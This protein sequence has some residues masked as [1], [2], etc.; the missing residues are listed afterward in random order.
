MVADINRLLFRLR[1]ISERLRSI[2]SSLEGV[3]LSPNNQPRDSQDSVSRSPHSTS[4]L[5]I[6][7]Q[8]P[9]D[10]SSSS[11]SGQ[12]A[13]A[14]HLSGAPASNPL[15][16]V[17]SQISMIEAVTTD[18]SLPSSPQ[19]WASAASGSLSSLN[20]T[21]QRLFAGVSVADV[22]TRNIMSTQEC[23]ASFRLYVPCS[24]PYAPLG[25]GINGCLS[26][27]FFSKIA[28]WIMNF[29]DIRDSNASALRERSPFLFHVMLLT[30]SCKSLSQLSL[31]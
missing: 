8:S 26:F 28:P 11:Q 1:E 6:V 25:A 31:T 29:D 13:D 30:S 22:I 3:H 24:F 12:G 20:A 21:M 9:D 4:L 2:E 10:S 5:P 19:D 27:S 23:E 15:Q 14:G 7:P 17:I 16:T 18:K